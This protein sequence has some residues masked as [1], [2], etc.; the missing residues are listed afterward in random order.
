MSEQLIKKTEEEHN[1]YIELVE[2]NMDKKLTKIRDNN[3]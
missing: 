3:G 2:A 1:K